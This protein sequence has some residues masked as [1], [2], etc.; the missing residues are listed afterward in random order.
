MISQFQPTINKVVNTLWHTELQEFAPWQQWGIRAIRITYLVFREFKDGLLTLRA[1]SLVYTSLLS[2]VP[3]LAVSFSVLKAF[4]VH[5]QIEPLLLNMLEPLGEQG[6]EITQAIIS[7]VENMRVGVLGALG[8]AFLL[9]TVISMIQKVESAFNYTWHV[10]NLRSLSQRF[11]NYLSV[12]IIGPVLVFSAMGLTATIMSSTVVQELGSWPV[13]GTLIE[14]GGRLVPYLLII[15]AFTFI[16][17]FMPNVK[18]RFKSALVGAVVAGAMWETTGWVFTAFVVTATKYTAIYSALATLI[19]F[20]FWLYANWVILLLGSNIAYYHQHPEQ[21]QLDPHSLDLSIRQKEKIALLVMA[22]VGKHLYQKLP[23]WSVPTLANTMGV[24]M[25]ALQPVVDA[26]LHARILVET[27]DDPP[28]LLPQ[29]PPEHIMVSDI[30][31][32]VRCYREAK[33][34]LIVS[35]DNVVDELFTKVEQ[36]MDDAMAG[37]TLR[38]IARLELIDLEGS[39]AASNVIRS[40]GE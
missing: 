36:A 17:I 21:C 7:F 8:L 35:S 20:M 1:M 3:L 11:S 27:S 34:E 13:I 6:V 38:D 37:K 2:L 19:I 18:V 14:V 40:I 30:L 5:N 16:Y 28:I 31:T 22:L 32:S 33:N 25:N 24:T 10:S 23:G 9:Y 4:G 15:I 29:Q 39:G 12:L 26:L